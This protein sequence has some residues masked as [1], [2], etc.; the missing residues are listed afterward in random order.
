ML[1]NEIKFEEQSFIVVKGLDQDL[2]CDFD[3]DETEDVNL[4]EDDEFPEVI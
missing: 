3:S 2:A 4:A 1:L